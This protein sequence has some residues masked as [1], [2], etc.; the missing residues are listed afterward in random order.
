MPLNPE[1]IAIVA[2][3]HIGDF[4]FC[5]PAVRALRRGYPSAR[6]S[7]FLS[8]QN[9]PAARGNPD[10]DEIIVVPE[11]PHRAFI[12][13]ASSFKE[14][15]FDLVVCLPANVRKYF[16]SFL[17]GGKVRLGLY[18]ARMLVGGLMAGMFL[19]RRLRVRTDP[20]ETERRNLTVEHEVEQYLRLP[21][22]LGLSVED[23]NIV[24]PLEDEERRFAGD[25]MKGAGLLP[26]DFILGIQYSNRWFSD[27]SR[28]KNFIAF[29]NLLKK[30]RPSWKILLLYTHSREEEEVRYI[31]AECGKNG[32]IC[33][34]ALHV[35]KWAAILGRCS[36]FMTIDGGSA[37][38]AGAL[39]V[40][41]VVLY[42]P[43]YYRYLVQRWHPWGAP[44]RAVKNENFSSQE[45][46]DAGSYAGKAVEAVI[47]A[48]KELAGE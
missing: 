29:I 5:T 25:F 22:S 14:R 44:W 45:K 46:E 19:T 24:F 20:A 48:M 32:I 47:S 2:P 10:V 27:S 11:L 6:I 42:S 28:K 3:D 31:M 15:N 9:A 21:A 35:K 17:L 26:T 30:T 8:G 1:K 4:L 37:A 7:L 18:Y 16:F 41:V 36:L 23:K 40:P 34:G 12:G 43:L 13:W 33:A 38:V 39:K